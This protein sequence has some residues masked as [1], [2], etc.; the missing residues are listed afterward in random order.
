MQ[1]IY[2]VNPGNMLKEVEK[3][4]GDKQAANKGCITKLVTTVGNWSVIFCEA[5]WRIHY[6][7][8]LLRGKG[9]GTFS[10]CL[11]A[12]SGTSCPVGSRVSVE[13]GY[14]LYQITPIMA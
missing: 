4:D 10:S 2:K 9:A 5:M 12:A 8:T 6:G 7:I 3:Q 14:L 1:I 11:R 13:L